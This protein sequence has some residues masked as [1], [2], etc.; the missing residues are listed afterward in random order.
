MKKKLIKKK[1]NQIFQDDM[2]KTNHAHLS[3]KKIKN[4]RKKFI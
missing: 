3:L 2:I 1:T 4:S